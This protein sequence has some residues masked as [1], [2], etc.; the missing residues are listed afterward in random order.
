MGTFNSGRVAAGR[1]VGNWEESVGTRCRQS[2][3]F[4]LMKECAC[5]A[6]TNAPQEDGSY[7][8]Y[9]TDGLIDR[10][11]SHCLGVATSASIM[12]PY[13]PQ[14]TPWA[15]PDPTTQ[16]GAI[17]PMGSSMSQLASDMSFIRSTATRSAT[18]AA[19]TMPSPRSCQL[20]YC[21]RKSAQTE[22]R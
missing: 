19:A 21:F 6:D 20:R 9:Y 15:C 12:G 18:A 11:Q 7:V 8:M 17:D 5:Q 2:G 22:F 14:S 3:R 10:P 16:G 1:C 4:T 13:I